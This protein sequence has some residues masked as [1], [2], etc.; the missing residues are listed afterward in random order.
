MTREKQWLADLSLL[1]IAVVWG[2]SYLITKIVLTD[3]PVYSF[4]FI[5]FLLTVV[6]MAALTW[7]KLV[8]ASKETWLSGLV[9]GLLLAAIFSSETW[10]INFTSASNAGFLISLFVIFTPLAESL[11]SR[12]RLHVSLLGVIL[13][14]VIGTFLLTMKNG[15]HFN[16]GDLL[17]LLAAF[18]R[19]VQ[20]SVTQKMTRGKV[21]DSGALTTIQLG[22][23]ALIMGILSLSA[24]RHPFSFASS[25]V[26]FW[27]L[28]AYLAIFC[29]LLAFYIQ[30][31]MIRR[32]SPT[33]VGLLTG[34]EPLFAALFA[35]V[36]GGEKLSPLEW[37]GGLLIVAATYLGRHV[38]TRYNRNAPGTREDQR[39]VS[40]NHE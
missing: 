11:I 21:M 20:M 26:L 2:S 38:E 30:L 4:L 17:M 12:K 34:T 15:Y 23:V 36:L 3:I 5:R 6:I 40:Q 9:F 1:F 13:L 22:V 8:S 39:L 33:R 28:T 18:L 10:G 24:D 19:A 7:R 31:A 29:T 25:S 27:L 35:V 37:L 16:L 32:T 14:S